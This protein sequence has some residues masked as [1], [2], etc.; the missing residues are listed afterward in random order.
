MSRHP[1]IKIYLNCHRCQYGSVQYCN[2]HMIFAPISLKLQPTPF[3]YLPPKAGRSCHKST[4]TGFIVWFQ[5]FAEVTGLT[6]E[7]T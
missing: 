5:K 3:T 2:V 1:E 4:E 6:E 7:I